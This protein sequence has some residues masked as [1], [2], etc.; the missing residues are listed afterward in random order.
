M[1]L[2]KF[3]I[4]FFIFLLCSCKEQTDPTIDYGTPLNTISFDFEN[5]KKEYN[6]LISLIDSIEVVKLKT[7]KD[8]LIGS[9]S[10]ILCDEGHI[11]ILDERKSKAIFK[12][13][14]SGE[15]VLKISNIGKGPGEFIRPTDFFLLKDKLA[16]LDGYSGKIMFY[17]KTGGFLNEFSTKTM[18]ERFGKIDTNHFCMLNENKSSKFSNYN[19]SIVD[20][21]GNTI[22]KLMKIPPFSKDKNL[23]LYKPTDY[24]GKEL[25]YTNIFSN[26]IFR[27]LKDSIFVKYY[28]DFGKNSLNGAFLNANKKLTASDLLLILNKK[29]FV[30]SIDYFNENSK[31][32]FFQ[33]LKK[34]DV[35]QVYY[36]KE[37]EEAYLFSYKSFPEWFKYVARPYIYSDGSMFISVFEPHLTENIKKRHLKDISEDKIFSKLNPI[38]KQTDISDN[39]VIIIY[40]FK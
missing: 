26:N 30:N 21:N 40:Y 34:G 17:S 6:N 16:L 19:I 28:F 29:D 7:N 12:Y 14:K 24:F 18:A 25:L 33:C 23:S 32:I 3:I 22:K 2:V 11:Y 37:R 35:F 4:V 38:I 13:T 20:N 9:I 8:Y 1:D 31:Y 15:F 36:N 5:D 39:P 27:I 10:K